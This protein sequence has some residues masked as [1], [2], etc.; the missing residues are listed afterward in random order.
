MLVI[1]TKLIYMKQPFFDDSTK[2]LDSLTISVLIWN[3]FIL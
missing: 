1:E 2:F 3:P